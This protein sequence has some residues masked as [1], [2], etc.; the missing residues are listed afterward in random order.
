MK[1]KDFPDLF[2]ATTELFQKQS[3]II[4]QHKRSRPGG[5]HIEIA[6]KKSHDEH[7]QRHRLPPIYP[8][9]ELPPL[10]ELLN[11]EEF[12]EHDELRWQL[13]KWT[14]AEK[15]LKHHN[16]EDIPTNYLLDI[17]TL[18]FLTSKGF[19]KTAEADLILYTIKSVEQKTTD[20]IEAPAVVDVRAFQI[21]FLY[22]KIYEYLERSLEVTGLK[23]SMTVR[24]ILHLINLHS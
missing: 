15:K 3:G 11:G 19:I 6:T 22:C 14:I 17:L 7:F 16:L 5:I 4:L 8:D 24:I 9:M 21:A 2:K 13:V 12:P 23:K 1:A 20:G 10:I 18:V